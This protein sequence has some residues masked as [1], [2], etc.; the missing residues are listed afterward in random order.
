MN[1]DSNKSKTFKCGS[2]AKRRT[3]S[4]PDMEQQMLFETDEDEFLSEELMEKICTKENLNCAYKKVVKNKGSS[5]VDG[6]TVKE[7]GPWI[8]V[9]KD[10][11]IYSY[12]L[13][14]R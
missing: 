14:F 1:G 10:E 13:N 6:K 3:S 4:S 2:G 9:H 11:L 8:K 5:G 7:L 12:A